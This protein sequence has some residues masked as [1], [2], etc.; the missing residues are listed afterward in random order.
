L[1]ADQIYVVRKAS[2]EAGEE[3]VRGGFF[4]SPLKFKNAGK[5]KG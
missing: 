2:I 1:L 4:Q 5:K 3:G